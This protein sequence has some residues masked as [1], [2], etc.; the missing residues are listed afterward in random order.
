MLVPQAPE[1]C[2]CR[3]VFLVHVSLAQI[4]VRRIRDDGV[5][6]SDTEPAFEVLQLH[7]DDT[8]AMF[9]NSLLSRSTTSST[10]APRR[11][12]DSGNDRLRSQ[13]SSATR[14][15]TCDRV[16]DERVSAHASGELGESSDATIVVLK[17]RAPLATY[18]VAPVGGQPRIESQ[19][20]GER[21]VPRLVSSPRLRYRCVSI[22]CRRHEINV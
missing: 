9:E 10:G 1:T 17:L 5:P 22:G 20:E 7:L 15:R 11:Q 16:C 3:V 13:A 14:P 19:V 12:G 6:A 21:F 18:Q 2:P 8:T 4:D